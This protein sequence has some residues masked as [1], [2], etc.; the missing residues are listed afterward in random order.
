MRVWVAFVIV[1]FAL[2]L[3]AYIH[4]NSTQT[5]HTESATIMANSSTLTIKIPGFENGALMPAKYTCDGAG[6]NPAI[7]I[8]GVPEGAQSLALTVEDPDVPKQ[9]LPSGVF[10]H[11]VLYNISVP[12]IDVTLDPSRPQIIIPENAQYPSD[13]FMAIGGKNGSGSYGYVAPC[14]PP[15]YQPAEHRY[16][17]TLYA[18][19]IM[20]P[21]FKQPPT[22]EELLSAIQEHIIAQAQYIGRYKRP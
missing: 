13:S 3:G 15:E 4:F 2:S 9:I 16:V 5:I 21:T 20:G 8:F 19:D 7:E 17:F 1:G 22:K 12:L 10:D 18:L 14:P 11:W 6:V